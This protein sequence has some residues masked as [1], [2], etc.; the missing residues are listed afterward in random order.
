MTT[1]LHDNYDSDDQPKELDFNELS[2][3]DDYQHDPEKHTSGNSIAAMPASGDPAALAMLAASGG[4][5]T[6]IPPDMMGIEA[7]ALW[8]RI[9]IAM[10][11]G[12][13]ASTPSEWLIR[14]VLAELRKTK[15][16]K[17]IK[18]SAVFAGVT[19]AIAKTHGVNIPTHERGIARDVR[20][21]YSTM[22]QIR[23]LATRLIEEKQ[24]DLH[25]PEWLK[26][27]WH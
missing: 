14:A 7:K 5:V 19:L 11:L 22:I 13:P 3:P 12:L 4:N 24:I 27:E 20:T 21:R 2:F 1:D 15:A 6:V 9:Q 16:G 23:K 17:K 25:L 26:A 8:R 10:M 18:V